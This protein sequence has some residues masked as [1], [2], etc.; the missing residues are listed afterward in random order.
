M[1]Q[2][3]FQCLLE[4]LASM[5]EEV[6]EEKK[7]IEKIQREIQLIEAGEF[8]VS[9]SVTCG[10]KGKKPLKTITITGIPNPYYE[11]RLVILKHRIQSFVQKEQSLLKLI[12]KA[13]EG[14]ASITDSRMRRM[15]T[16]R[17]IEELSWVEVAHK[18]GKK[19]TADSCRMACERFFEK[20]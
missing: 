18:M 7:R 3:E 5:K 19:A 4:Q 8:L 14:I 17:Y 12:V 6:K 20:K 10:K 16:M 11:Q 13:E 9:D 15:L 1:G 2:M